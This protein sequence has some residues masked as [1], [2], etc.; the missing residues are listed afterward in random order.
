MDM[1]DTILVRP[2]YGDV[3]DRDQWVVYDNTRDDD[4]FLH[5]RALGDKQ[6]A[7]MQKLEDFGF[8]RPKHAASNSR[9]NL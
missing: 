5:G 6:W 9:A 8:V 2:F 3:R 7:I 1:S 4:I